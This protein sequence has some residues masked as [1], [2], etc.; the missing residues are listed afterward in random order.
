MPEPTPGTTLATQTPAADPAAAPPVPVT[1]PAAPTPASVQTDPAAPPKTDEPTA[2]PEAKVEG[3]PEKYE[4]T[5]P[6]DVILDETLLKAVEPALRELNLNNEQAS[7][8]AATFAEYQTQ[9]VKAQADAHVKQVND[10][11]A[12]VSADKEIGGPGKPGDL[13]AVKDAQ[14]ALAK[15]G[16]PELV[17]FLDASG[18]GS[19]PEIIRAFSKMGALIRE[20]AFQAGRPSTN[21]KR[22]P[23]Q[24]LWPDHK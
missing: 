19:H 2:K 11:V 7:K 16:S 20:P 17:A 3:A 4:L 22:T 23:E 10:W 1:D 13:Q 14:S 12:A 24:V 21:D 9:Q 5:L 8:L 15:F 6:K 18:I